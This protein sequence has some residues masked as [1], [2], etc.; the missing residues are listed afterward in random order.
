[1]IGVPEHICP[2]VGYTVS[3][4]GAVTEDVMSG[5]DALRPLIVGA[6][7]IN[8]DPFGGVPAVTPLPYLVSFLAGP[9]CGLL[10]PV[11]AIRRLLIIDIQDILLPGIGVEGSGGD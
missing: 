8:V 3:V 4:H 11:Y 5:P 2:L 10:D 7:S 1:M 6:G 9:I